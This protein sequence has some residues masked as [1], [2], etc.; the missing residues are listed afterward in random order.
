M[1]CQTTWRFYSNIIQLYLNCNIAEDMNKKLLPFL[2]FKEEK[3]DAACY[4][5]ESRVSSDES[6]SDSYMV[7]LETV[8]EFLKSIE[9]KYMLKT[10]LIT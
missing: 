7:G 5:Y 3:I 9:N 8:E 4:K 10:M 6:L 2:E 1:F